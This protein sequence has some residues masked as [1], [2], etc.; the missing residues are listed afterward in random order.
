M[1]IDIKLDDDC[2]KQKL[3]NIILNINKQI[4]KR[5]RR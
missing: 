2:L 5:G 1:A 3:F 4:Y